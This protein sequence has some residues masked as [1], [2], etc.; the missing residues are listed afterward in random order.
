MKFNDKKGK[1]SAA[2]AI[3]TVFGLLVLGGVGF[4]VYNAYG[5][6]QTEITGPNSGTTG[7]GGTQIITVNPIISA[8][9]IDDQQSGTAVAV[10]GKASINSDSSYKT[11][12]LGTDTA[13]P[14]Q[15]LKLFL[16]NGT[17][18]HNIYVDVGE[19]QVGSFPVEVKMYHNASVTE[20]IYNANAATISNNNTLGTQQGVTNYTVAANGAYSIKDEMSGTSLQSTQDMVC[21]FE[22]TNKTAASTDVQP[23][24]Y[25]DS[26]QKEYPRSTTKVP[27]A[28]TADKQD[29][30][31]GA[32]GVVY[33]YDVPALVNA[34]TRTDYI[35][36][37]TSTNSAYSLAYSHL[38]KTCYTKE[39]FIDPKT[40]VATYGIEDSNGN[41][42]SLGVYRYSFWFMP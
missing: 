30:N 4:L 5:Q 35:A 6:S 31:A 41:L 20:K 13:I 11:I 39:W 38:A 16:T 21:F 42:K 24:Q 18:Y 29:L 36:V 25:L 12:T 28:W 17:S 23:V 27:L 37:A 2:M 7:G 9:S 10:S 34:G 32:N 22:L 15:K 26:S 40:G 19:V 3:L 14:G 1:F 8:A 33:A